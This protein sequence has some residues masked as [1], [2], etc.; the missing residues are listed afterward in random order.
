MNASLPRPIPVLALL[1]TLCFTLATVIQPQALRLSTN[2]PGGDLLTHALGE[3]RRLFANHFFVKAD[4]Y[5]HNGYY[6]SFIQQSYREGASNHVH[7]AE[8]HTEGIAGTKEDKEEEEHEKAMAF[9]DTPSD[10]I[11]RFGRHFYAST[12]SHRE[13][14]GEAREILPWLKLSAELD[15]QKIDIYTTASYWLRHNLKK[16]EEAELFLREGLKANPQSYDILFELGKLYYEDRHDTEHARNLFEL[17][18]R[19]WDEADVA[20]KKPDPILGDALL[21]YLVSLEEK[22][23]R[24]KESLAYLEKELTISP[25]PDAIRQRMDEM[26]SKISAASAK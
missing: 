15:P 8:H 14:E 6:P 23:G 25:T 22:N 19:R 17:A 26:K 5:F 10:W 4:V 16:S 3:G 2:E 7:I 1:F 9:L 21:A 11:D 12:H 20:G 24:L 18:L 13:K